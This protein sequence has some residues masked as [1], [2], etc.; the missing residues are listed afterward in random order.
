MSHS[1]NFNSNFNSNFNFNFHATS[2]STFTHFINN[3]YHPYLYCSLNK[4][5][6]YIYVIRN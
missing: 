6:T 1:P 3:L 2:T 5:E 4:L